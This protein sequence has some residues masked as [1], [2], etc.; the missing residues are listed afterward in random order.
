MFQMKISKMTFKIEN[1][2]QKS[3]YF[4]FQIKK[5]QPLLCK[6]KGS[7]MK[8]AK[9]G[10]QFCMFTLSQ[11]HQICN[12]K[13]GCKICFYELKKG[14]CVFNYIFKIHF[15]Y[16]SGI[17]CISSMSKK[18]HVLFTDW[19]CYMYKEHCSKLGVKVLSIISSK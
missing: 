19:I 16:V 2:Y 6:E 12:Y 8:S 17:K 14:G 3:C 9:T 11:Y 13:W 5:K 10:I 7:Q 4:F 15:K 1:S 18:D